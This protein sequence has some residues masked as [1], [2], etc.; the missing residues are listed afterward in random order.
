MKYLSTLL[1]LL[2][3]GCASIPQSTPTFQ[4]KYGGFNGANA[5]EDKVKIELVGITPAGISYRWVTDLSAW[6][7]SHTD[8]SQVLAC[9]FVRN[10][11]GEYVGGKFDWVSSS[12]SYRG[13]S[14]LSNYSGWT[15]KDVPNPTTLYF[16]V[17]HKDGRRRSNYIKTEWKR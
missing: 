14:H 3:A 4:W 17:V 2:L 16:V 12:R 7:V 11:A 5:V 15:L 9:A 6:G 8:A 1:V 13:F 10:N